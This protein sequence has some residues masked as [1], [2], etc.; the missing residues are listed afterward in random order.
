MA[1]RQ[2]VGGR[3][4]Q[5][6]SSIRRVRRRRAHF[7]DAHVCY[8][9]GTEIEEGLVGDSGPAFGMPDSLEQR[10]WGEASKMATFIDIIEP[11]VISDSEVDDVPQEG[12][13]K[14][15]AFEPQQVQQFKVI[16]EPEFQIIHRWVSPM[17]NKVQRWQVDEDSIVPVEFVLGPQPQVVRQLGSSKESLIRLQQMRIE[18]L[19]LLVKSLHSESQ[20]GVVKMVLGCDNCSGLRA[21]R[22]MAR[23]KAA[24]ERTSRVGTPAKV[25]APLE[26]PA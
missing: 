19:S 6:K 5:D 3:G 12:S 18:G 10:T 22:G 26:M 11:I 2:R 21:S 25:C 13:T 1:G 24:I 16:S 23:Q 14:A 4:V 17:V 7:V 15:G 9:L 8:D 20:P